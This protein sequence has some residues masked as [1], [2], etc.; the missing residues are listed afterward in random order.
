MVKQRTRRKHNERRVRFFSTH[1][2]SRLVLE[3]TELSVPSQQGIIN[4]TYSVERNGR[5]Q[6]DDTGNEETFAT[7][8]QNKT[9]MMRTAKRTVKYSK[10]MT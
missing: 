10:L 5:G 6:E 4:G 2:E 8:E 1:V 7:A 3:E 9:M